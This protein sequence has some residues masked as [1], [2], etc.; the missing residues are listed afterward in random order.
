LTLDLDVADRI[1]PRI[2]IEL[3]LPQSRELDGLPE[4]RWRG[5]LDHL[6][7]AGLCTGARRRGVLAW[8]GCSREQ[9]R[10]RAQSTLV[11]RG[12]SHVK[13]EGD[14]S[15]RLSAKAYIGFLPDRLTLLFA[16]DDIGLEPAIA[17]AT[18]GSVRT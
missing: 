17:S 11:F 5:F 16:D 9:F 2:G 18:V 10:H 3:S 4:E 1:M 7:G 6:A 13:L 12:L 14:R 15:E 8:A